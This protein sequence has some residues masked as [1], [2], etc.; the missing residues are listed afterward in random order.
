LL[1]PTDVTSSVSFLP[2]TIAPAT[3]PAAAPLAT[4]AR[5]PVS[6]SVALAKIPL[7]VVLFVVFG[8]L[9]VTE[10]FFVPAVFGAEDFFVVSVFVFADEAFFPAVDLV[11]AGEAFFTE[12]VDF[13]LVSFF[14]VAIIFVAGSYSISRSIRRSPMY[15]FDT[16]LLRNGEDAKDMPNARSDTG[17]QPVKPRFQV[18][19]AKLSP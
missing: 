10:V 16:L 17:Q 5:A 15:R 3:A 12:P 6:A 8:L 7:A 11:F 4:V 18:F 1:F 19:S 14:A 9:F 13:A 2:A